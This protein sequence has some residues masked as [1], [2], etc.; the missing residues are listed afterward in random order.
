MNNKIGS[1]ILIVACVGLAVALLVLKN[2]SDAQQKKDAETILDFSNQWVE[3]SININELNQANVV[4][5]NDV[6]MKTTA[7]SALSNQLD[8]A[9][10]TLT[11]T[12]ASL[13]SSQEQI[14]NLNTRVADLEAQN[15]VLDE[16]A[17][18]LSN[19]I[20]QLDT[21]IAETEMKLATSRTNNAFLESE[22]KRQVAE[23]TEL[24]RKFNDLQE[25][26]VQVHKLRDEL[27]IARRL[28]WMREG[29]DPTKP[30]KGGQLLMQRSP[31][32]SA[33]AAPASSPYSSLNVEVSSDGS[34]HV[35]PPL[36][37]SPAAGTNAPP[38]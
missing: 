6:A 25:V 29:T 3:A 13:A 5:S 33:S 7:M 38:K 22:L 35:I 27:L 26:R 20:A 28:E 30:M 23:R 15:Q 2:R 34:V 11:T 14:T 32:P 8:A 16:R 19:T 36:T 31:P 21:Q 9:S 24:E 12:T 37:N 4:L 10:N 1:A 18:S 17:N